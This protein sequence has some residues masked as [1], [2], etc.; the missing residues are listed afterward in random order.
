MGADF[1]DRRLVD[2]RANGDARFRSGANA[3]GVDAI[4]QLLRK[5]VINAGLHQ[6]PVGA[7]AGLATVAEF[8]NQRAFNG[9]IEIGIVEHDEGRI[10]AQFQRQAL[11]AVGSAAH[12]K[13]TDA[14]GAG[15]GD[16][17]NR[18]IGHDFIA[19]ISRHAGDDVDDARGN[20]RPFGE[21][22]KRQR[23]IGCEFRRLDDAGI[24]EDAQDHDADIAD[25]IQRLHTLTPQQSRVLTMLAEGMSNKQIAYNLSVLEA[26]AK[27]HVTS[28]LRKLKVG[29][30]TQ[31]VI[32]ISKFNTMIAAA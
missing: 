16:L 32:Q 21:H 10:A 28:I 24:Y 12:Q 18:L 27:A 29:T 15:E 7:D 1:R 11:D 31:A 25:L 30:R 9:K 23:R 2:H 22:T 6:N 13:R 26:T 5:G 20:A 3:H 8:R 14:G 19:D 17:A 4:R